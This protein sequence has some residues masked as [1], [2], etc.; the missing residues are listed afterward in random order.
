MA[1]KALK[2]IRSL[3]R[4]NG[5]DKDSVQII[6]ETADY[7]KC[8]A[9]THIELA[10]TIKEE[11]KLGQHQVEQVIEDPGQLPKI[12]QKNTEEAIKNT[13][14]RKALAGI[15]LN[16][17]D[18]GF[19]VHGQTFDVAP[20]NKEFGYYQPCETCEGNGKA[21]CPKC[22]GQGKEQ[23]GQ[24]GGRKHINCG[25]CKGMGTTQGQDGERKTCNRCAGRKQLGCPLCQQS[26]ITNCRNCRGAGEVKCDPCRSKGVFTIAVTVEYTMKTL[27]EIDRAA[28][29]HPA[30]K[31]IETAGHKL[32]SDNHVKIIGEPVKREDGGL[33]IQYNAE[34]PYSELDIGVNGHPM[35]VHMFGFKAKMLKLTNFVD[36]LVE[37]NYALLL[38]AAQDEGN[39]ADHIQKAARS[40]LISEGIYFATQY[41]G[42]KAMA[43]LK[44]DFPMGVSNSLIKDII[45]QSKHAFRNVSR[46]SYWT[47]FGS[48]L[49]VATLLNIA[50]FIGGG[51]DI[52]A[53]QLTSPMLL[54][55]VDLL[56][57][58]I[59]GFVIGYAAQYMAKRPIQKVI[60]PLL[61]DKKAADFKIRNQNKFWIPYAAAAGI[62]IFVVLLSYFMGKSVPMWLSSL[63]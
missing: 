20:F 42:K 39:I 37:K 8:Q 3:G 21:R 38:Q 49:A 48:G 35:K 33:A 51:R 10:H 24:C 56:L 43:C 18:K 7:I 11:R 30:V 4:G 22:Q 46:K 26:G 41:P 16:R 17:P 12:I 5:V 58:P 45:V 59:S 1:Q 36:R 40:R 31:M 25:Y 55:I 63:I 54:S 60:Q 2:R 19:G 14:A 44:K 47:G 23:C 61:K 52:V 29:P 32:V 62:F 15:L 34:F 6:R 50:Y 13:E 57:I 28:L 9:I 53:A 27:F